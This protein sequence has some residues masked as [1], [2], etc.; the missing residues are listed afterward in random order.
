MKHATKPE[1]PEERERAMQVV[2]PPVHSILDALT[3][4]LARLVAVNE[5]SGNMHFREAF[6][7]SLNEWRVIGVVHALSPITFGRVRKILLMDKGQ[8]SRVIKQLADQGILVTRPAENDARKVEITLTGQGSELHD[9]V[10]K[11][12]AERNEHVVETLTPAECREFM[13]ILQKITSHNEML[14]EF[15]GVLK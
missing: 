7:L 6:G 1:L 12:T 13:R 10:L 5:L 4:R 14:S 3:F 2:H 15:S 11:F 8:L 9:R